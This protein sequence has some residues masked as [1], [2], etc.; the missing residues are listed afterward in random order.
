ME[1]AV[2]DLGSTTFHLQHL[3]VDEAQRFTATLDT[4]RTP[5]LGARVFVDGFIDRRGWLES[6]EAVWELLCA[7]RDCRPDHTCVVATSAIRS[8]SNG[9]ALVREIERRHLVKVRVLEPQEEA[10]LAYL[11]QTT[12]A[13]VGGRRV[14]VVD[15]GG[16]SVEL[17]VGE[18]TRCIHAASLPIGAVRMRAQASELAFGRQAASLLALR[19]REPLVPALAA[20]RELSPDV[21]VFCSGSARAARKLLMRHTDQPGK[22]GPVELSALR[23]QLEEHLGLADSEL[24]GLGVEP[25]RANTVLVAAT[26]IVQ[27]LDLLGVTDAYV[28]DKGLRDGVALEHYRH[29]L[30]RARSRSATSSDRVT[31]ADDASWFVRS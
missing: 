4:K 17:A 20:V 29:Q 22:T 13:A 27:I 30:A 19:L 14:A 31:A 11:G 18:G 9:I 15:L 6:L 2:L 26:I 23:Y 21:V 12:S 25:L 5:L 1:I 28:S 10:Q 8:A 7:S 24:I 16:G 3:R